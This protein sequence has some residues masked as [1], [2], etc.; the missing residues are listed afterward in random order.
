VKEKEFNVTINHDYLPIQGFILAFVD[1]C[2][3]PIMFNDCNSL[4]F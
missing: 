2:G 4:L 1:E 3:K